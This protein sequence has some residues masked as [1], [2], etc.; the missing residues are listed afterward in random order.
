M[1]KQNLQLLKIMHI[2][3]DLI[4]TAIAFTSAFLLIYIFGGDPYGTAI[5]FH[6]YISLLKV[7]LPLWLVI[8]LNSPNSYSYRMKSG[9]FLITQILKPILTG[10]GILIAYLTISSNL[11]VIRSEIFVFIVLDMV[12]L[13][14]LRRSIQRVLR[15][16]RAKGKDQ[17]NI[18][19]VGSGKQAC[20][21]YDKAKSN[22]QWGINILGFLSE[23]GNRLYNGMSD[24]LI[25]KIKD[26]PYILNHNQVDEV[27]ISL[28]LSSF[29][30]VED[31]LSQ[32]QEQGVTV[33]IAAEFLKA[34]AR[35]FSANDIFGSPVLS[36]T[37]APRR[38]DMVFIKRVVDIVVSGIMLIMLS[39]VF[40]ILAIAIRLDSKGP[41]FYRWKVVGKNRK[42]FT[43]YKFRSMVVSADKLKIKLLNKNEM[44]GVV[45]KMKNDP[46]ITRVGK[47]IRKYSLDELPQLYN[48]FKGDMSLVGPR[49]P[50]QTE[51][52]SFANWHR[53]KLSVKPGITCLW[54]VSG[55]NNINDF[56]EWV[57]MDLD[58]IDRWSLWMDLK[59]LARTIPTV[60]S[61]K[62]A[63]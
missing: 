50:L 20:E 15:Y 41:V 63:S 23:D 47:F 2:A 54:Q 8:F 31:L 35:N 55:R 57:K 38:L 60:I 49:P 43:G 59:I 34:N 58:Y 6:R 24:L 56:D 37:S 5:K 1:I 7:I 25:G 14:L 28:P 52:G 27:F 46:R 19:I 32:C 16:Y 33:H 13:Y 11:M 36:F 4:L 26:L 30:K 39:P 10:A 12:M 18:L 9:P 29:H 40:L 22:S 21:F 17:K 45:F 62:G 51:V 42:E 53:R 61:G 44:K 3:L 48:V